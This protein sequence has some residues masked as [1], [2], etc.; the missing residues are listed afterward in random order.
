MWQ[1][2]QEVSSAK[3]CKE[4]MGTFVTTI[5]VGGKMI[6]HL[7]LVGPV[8]RLKEWGTDSPLVCFH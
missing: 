4:V 8:K 5:E 1:A 3:A 7:G 2:M 6:K